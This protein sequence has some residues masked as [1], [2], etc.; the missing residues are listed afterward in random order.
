M[1]TSTDNLVDIYLQTG[2]V[3]TDLAYLF[4]QYTEL[5][6][7]YHNTQ[8]LAHMIHVLME[9]FEDSDITYSEW[10]KLLDVENVILAIY[11]HDII[12]DIN[13]TD[14]EEKSAELMRIHLDYLPIEKVDKISK[15][16]MVTNGHDVTSITLDPPSKLMIYLDLAI[17]ASEPDAYDS[18]I[19]N[20]RL[21]Y[22]ISDLAWK[23]GRRKFLKS[24][25]AREAIFP[26]GL[27]LPKRLETVARKNMS[28]ELKDLGKF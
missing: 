20:L 10:L 25:L 9:Y 28:K 19:Y 14:N 21:E 12:H 13:R 1:F 5:S 23:H 6:R 26:S 24:M 15:Y 3:A 4:R 2:G 16:I 17:L 11:W 22:N 27:Y 18:Y 8:H 7:K